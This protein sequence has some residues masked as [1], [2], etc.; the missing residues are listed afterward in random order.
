M[1]TLYVKDQGAVIHRRGERLVVMK[2]NE[3]LEDIPILHV[4]QVVVLG[5]IQLTTPAVAL[6][7]SK[8]VDLVFLSTRGRYRGRLVTTGSRFA[9]LRHAQL[10]LLDDSPAVFSVACAV[11]QAKLNNQAQ[12]LRTLENSRA[13]VAVIESARMK[14]SQA[15]DLDILRGHEG[16]AGAAYFG[17]LQ[18]MIPNEW[19]FTKRIY[20]PPPDPV[21]AM[22]SLG[23]SLL[24]KDTLAAVEL[25]GLDPYLGFFHTLEYNRPSLCLDL[26]EPFR[27]AIDRW[28]LRLIRE[29]GVAVRDF[30]QEVKEDERKITLKEEP[31]RRYLQGYET[32]MA[33][34][35]RYPRQEEWTTRR[36]CLELQARALARRVLGEQSN[37]QPFVAND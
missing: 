31:L 6:L 28:V 20:H 25:V 2:E 7:M 21:N 5:N 17:A 33:E 11:V 36:R 16:A 15:A 32:V 26:M 27:P 19:G 34:R 3:V 29:G 10:R 18:A 1:G 4:E 30:K 22:L 9:R 14:A 35:A 13:A 24:L 23:Y 12:L 37:F 8:E